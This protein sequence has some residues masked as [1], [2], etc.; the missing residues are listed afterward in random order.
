MRLA[1]RALE[2]AELRETMAIVDNKPMM[3]ITTKSST[4]VNAARFDVCVRVCGIYD[5]R[6]NT[7]ILSQKPASH[8]SYLRGTLAV[9]LSIDSKRSAGV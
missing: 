3:E 1:S 7:Q 8:T 9:F 5:I 6:H 2:R 4:S